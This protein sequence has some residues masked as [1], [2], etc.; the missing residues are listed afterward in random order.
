MTEDLAAPPQTRPPH[1]S[2][3]WWYRA[4]WRARQQA[5]DE[6]NRQNRPVH[7]EPE[8]ILTPITID[9]LDTAAII[10]SVEVMR[11]WGADADTIAKELGKT[12]GSLEMR[13]RRAGRPDLGRVFMEARNALRYKPCP[14]C[15]HRTTVRSTRCR[16]CSFR[17]RTVGAA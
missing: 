10:E 3:H 15:G 13:M 14:D 2:R 17:V 11:E 6:H 8:R 16:P 1:I 9:T 4:T 12:V 7:V 5:I